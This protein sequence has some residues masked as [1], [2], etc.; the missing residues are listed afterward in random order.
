MEGAFFHYTAPT[1]IY[2]INA[3]EGFNRQLRKEAKG[4]S[5][6]PIMIVC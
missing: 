4:K 3:I 2:T 1:E 6:F 5:V